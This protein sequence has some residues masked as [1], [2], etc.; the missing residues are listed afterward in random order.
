M[1]AKAQCTID[2]NVRECILKGTWSG[3]VIE[4]P[5]EVKPEETIIYSPL[6]SDGDIILKRTS[7]SR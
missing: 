6:D 4:D 7:S 3:S 2:G 5:T 1:P